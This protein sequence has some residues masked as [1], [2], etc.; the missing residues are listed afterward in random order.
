MNVSM[1]IQ[2]QYG[3]LRFILNAGRRSFWLRIGFT[4]QTDSDFTRSDLKGCIGM[5]TATYHIIRHADGRIFYDGDPITLAEAQVMINEA[6]AHG[7]LE[8]NSFLQIDEDLLVIEL[9]AVS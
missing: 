5:T 7:T 9:D 3:V 1:Q 6:I 8:V 2:V 4:L